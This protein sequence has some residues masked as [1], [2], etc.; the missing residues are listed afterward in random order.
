MADW[1][2]EYIIDRDLLPGYPD[3]VFIEF[4]I[5]KRRRMI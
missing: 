1:V 5:K 4:E 3:L 2:L